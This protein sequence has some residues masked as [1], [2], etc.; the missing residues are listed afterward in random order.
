MVDQRGIDVRVAL[1]KPDGKKLIEVDSEHQIEGSETVLVV[2]EATG[3]YRL[4]VC[5]SE[6]TARTGRYEIKLEELRKATAEDKHRVAAESVFR[7]AEQ[8]QEGT[9]EAKRMSIEKYHEAHGLYRKAGDR[10]REAQ[11]L[12]K[13]G[14]VY[15]ALGEMQRSL[16]K[17]N[18]ALLILRAAGDRIGDSYY[19]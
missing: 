5:A 7:E 8:L 3:T 16:E 14:M 12:N 17:S 2:T 18:E 15:E 10:S 4:E 13:I 19:T 1:L 9:S 6:R 11:A